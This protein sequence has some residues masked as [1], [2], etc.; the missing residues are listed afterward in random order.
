M[1]TDKERRKIQKYCACPKI[2]LVALIFAFVD[3]FMMVP[4]EM[5]DDLVFHNKGFRPAG[6][7]TAI[8]FVV[9]NLVIF[10]YCTLAPRFGMKGQQWK[11]R[12]GEV[13]GA[14]ALQS[15][16]RLLSRSDNDTA[17]S[18][19]GALEIAGGISAVATV[20][21]ILLETRAK[22]EAIA[23]AYEIPVPS[24]KKQLIALAIVPMLIITGMYIPGYIQG[25]QEMKERIAACQEQISIVEKALTPVC[26]YVSADDPSERYK[27]YGY[28]V[29][30]YLK[31]RDSDKQA[32]YV[33]VDFDESGVVKEISYCEELDVNASLEENLSNIERDFE[34]LQAPLENLN[35]SVKDAD[36][37]AL[38]RLPDQF[39]EEFL[40][41][42]IYQKIHVYDGDSPVRISCS[43]DTEP[44]EDFDE[45][46]RPRVYLHLSA[47]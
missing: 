28:H 46:T 45:Y 42:S 44:E 43:F 22:V 17:K 18:V 10:C 12:S 41:G 24:I 26:E 34:K 33:Y 8:A 30:G 4:L 27:D 11:N 3:C 2:A 19:G 15:S 14:M 39:R 20:A 21:D 37:L 47:K 36:L 29:R 7:Y 13:A 32:C 9:I 1:L 25:N 6:M 38:H 16:G 5:I 31:E 35:V 40:A 23:E